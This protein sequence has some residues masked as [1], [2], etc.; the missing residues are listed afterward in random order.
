MQSFLGRTDES[1]WFLSPASYTQL[2]KFAGKFSV[3]AKHVL[4]YSQCE[5]TSNAGLILGKWC[6]TSGVEVGR[7][8]RRFTE[9]PV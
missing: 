6:E 9:D 2:E 1:D 7:T 4:R 3:R 5:I 8:I